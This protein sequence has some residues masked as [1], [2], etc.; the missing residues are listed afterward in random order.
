[1]EKYL[2]FE[3]H[4]KIDD[5]YVA[6]RLRR[7]YPQTVATDEDVDGLIKF[8]ANSIPSSLT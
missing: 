8:L 6:S 2:R 5:A 1:M 7:Q 3:N 4:A